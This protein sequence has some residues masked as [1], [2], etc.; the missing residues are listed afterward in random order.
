MKKF[1][2]YLLFVLLFID[3]DLQTGN[4]PQYVDTNVP[5]Y[6]SPLSYPDFITKNEDYFITRI[7]DVPEITAETYKLTVKGIDETELSFSLNDLL[8]LEMVEFPLTIE[9]IGNPENGSLLGTA[10]WKGLNIYNF[11]TSLGMTDSAGGVKYVAADGYFASHTL[12]QI[13]NNNV[14]GA[15]FMNDEPIPPIHGFP[16]RIINPGYYGVKQPA[17]VTSFEIIPSEDIG[18]SSNDYWAL[19]DWI[20]SPPMD[21]DCKIF[22]P[23]NNT[24][25]QIGDSLAVGGAAYGST[26]IT[27]VEISIDS[28]QSWQDTDI[29]KSMDADNVWIFWY[30]SLIFS[31]EDTYTILARATDIYGNVQHR[32]DSSTFDG[33]S[34]V[35]YVRIVV[36]K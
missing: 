7:S 21:A 30:K 34:K 20:V 5:L 26:R 19:Y 15:L 16:L 28:G 8:K 14:I 32:H 36:K 6:E 23:N 24:Q 33:N 3:C 13:K 29:V 17:W 31:V 22:F 11:L 4:E 12:D 10:Y 9:C 2:I 1:L 18:S 25:V 35:P 27:K